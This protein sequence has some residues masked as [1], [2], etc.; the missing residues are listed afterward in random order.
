[1]EIMEHY[2]C[3]RGPAERRQVGALQLPGRPR[4]FAGFRPPRHD[5]RPAGDD[6]AL[7]RHRLTLIDTGG[8]GRGGP[9][10]LRRRHRPRGRNG[11]GRGHRDH[12]RGRCAGGADAAGPDRGAS[13]AQEPAP[14][15]VAANK[16]DGEKQANLEG[17][18]SRLGFQGV[19]PVSAAHRRGLD[20]LRDAISPAGANRREARTAAPRVRPGWPSWAGPMWE[21]RR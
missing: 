20:D 19:F 12:F 15:F 7:G 1:M 3:H 2:R 21:S 6:G 9:R 16:V 11:A 17:E 14:V 18:F 13:F 4:Y 8:I 5:A 10:R